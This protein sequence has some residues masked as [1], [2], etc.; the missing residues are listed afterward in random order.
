MNC[1]GPF[2]LARLYKKKEKKRR[3]PASLSSA[4]YAVLQAPIRADH[5]SADDDEDYD[6]RYGQE[7]HV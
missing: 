4:P 1:L 3:R 6:D 7:W 5:S 2:E